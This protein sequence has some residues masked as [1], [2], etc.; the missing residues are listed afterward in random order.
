MS[1]DRHPRKSCAG[2][3]RVS[4]IEAGVSGSDAA[5]RDALVDDRLICLKGVS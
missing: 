4:V 2:G 3:W 5:A 1:E